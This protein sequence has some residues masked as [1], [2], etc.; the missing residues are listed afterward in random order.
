MK[1]ILLLIAAGILSTIVMDIGGGILRASGLTTGAPPELIGKWIESALKGNMFVD[2][3][4]TSPGTPVT[5]ATFLVYHYII[6]LLLTLAFYLLIVIFKITS[7][8]W[9]LPLLFGLSTTLI[10]ALIMYPG[11]GF[12]LFGQKGPAEYLLMRTALLNH[13]FFGIGLM[14]SFRLFAKH[15]LLIITHP[16]PF[17]HL[18]VNA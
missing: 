6:G 14:L 3:I 1:T 9:W 10:P 12:G 4:R 15:L 7:I 16:K 13:L 8:P 2:D 17:S 11:M 5:L 18:K